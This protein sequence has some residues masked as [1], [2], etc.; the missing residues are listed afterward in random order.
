MSE[1]YLILK[2]TDTTGIEQEKATRVGLFRGWISEVI[3]SMTTRAD[4]TE[5]DCYSD[6]LY[7][8]SGNIQYREDS[9]KA[10]SMGTLKSIGNNATMASADWVN[11]RGLLFEYICE[12]GNWFNIKNDA[13]VVGTD[14]M[15][16]L[17]GTGEDI[18]FVR[19][20]L[21]SYDPDM[22]NWVL[23]EYVPAVWQRRAAIGADSGNTDIAAAIDLPQVGYY[24]F[25]VYV[26]VEEVDGGDA[27]VNTAIAQQLSVIT[28]DDTPAVEDSI[29]VD[30]S[31]SFTPDVTSSAKMFN[32]SLQG[33]GIIY[34]SNAVEAN[35]IIYVNATL[36]NGVSQNVLE[37]YIHLLYL[38]KLINV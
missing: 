8:A 13:A 27:A 11:I 17:T 31:P 30:M 25:D 7:P 4:E 35:R 15:P 19:R 21:F 9:D 14:C 16:I 33:S 36:S 6:N 2:K 3:A 22:E 26:E 1:W 23:I 24:H 18:Y 38:G 29:L 34:V 20:A 10:G 12:P 5:F 28:Y 37:G 32:T